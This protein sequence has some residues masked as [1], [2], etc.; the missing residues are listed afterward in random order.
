M[1]NR[2][3]NILKIFINDKWIYVDK[4][5]T[6]NDI[7]MNKNYEV[8]CYYDSNTSKFSDFVNKTYKNFSKLF[9]SRDKNL[10]IQIK[11]DVDYILWN[12]M[13]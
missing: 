11:K 4:E 7:L 1:I 12:N 5:E 2:K 6:M 9:D 8:D 10:W 13:E 3:E